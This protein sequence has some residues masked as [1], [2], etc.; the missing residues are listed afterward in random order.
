MIE[1]RPHWSHSAWTRFGVSVLYFFLTQGPFGFSQ[2]LTEREETVLPKTLVPLSRVSFSDSSH[3]LTGQFSRSVMS[4]PL[5]PHRLQHARLACPSPTPRAYRNSCPLSQW[6]HPAISSSVVS[7]SSCL[8]SFPAS[9]S[10]SMSQLFT[11]G[12]QRIGASASVLPMNIQDWSPLGW[13]GW[14][15]ASLQNGYFLWVYKRIKMTES[16]LQK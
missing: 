9:G 6:C 13:T 10:F 11:S 2:L 7:F 3:A 4:D 12:D 5:R 1:L 8:Q 14:I 15:S 16:F